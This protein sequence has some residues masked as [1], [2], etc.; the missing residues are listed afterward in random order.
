MADLPSATTDGAAVGIALYHS[1]PIHRAEVEAANGSVL[2]PDYDLEQFFDIDTVYSYDTRADKERFDVATMVEVADQSLPVK[3]RDVVM[4]H[5]HLDDHIDAMRFT[6]QTEIV[7]VSDGNA[8]EDDYPL[9]VTHMKGNR[10]LDREWVTGVE[11]IARNHRHLHAAA[12][13]THPGGGHT[14]TFIGGAVSLSDGNEAARHVVG[15]R[16]KRNV[17]V[18]YRAVRAD[19]EQHTELLESGDTGILDASYGLEWD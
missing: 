15:P 2:R 17:E 16:G 18:Q 9:L 10:G 3:H 13:V 1:G 5:S 7:P 14:G 4:L 11:G 19:S 6:N 12:L 8:P